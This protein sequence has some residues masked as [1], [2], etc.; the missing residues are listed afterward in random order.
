MVSGVLELNST[1]KE[2]NQILQQKYIEGWNDAMKNVI[3]DL[4]NWNKYEGVFGDGIKAAIERIQRA[5]SK[6]D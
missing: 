3:V 2:I 1:N 4:N 6:M 5:V